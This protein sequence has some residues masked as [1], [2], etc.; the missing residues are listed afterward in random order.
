MG[1]H[2]KDGLCK[3]REEGKDFFFE[4]KNLLL[5]GAR[6]WGPPFRCGHEKFALLK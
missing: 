4:K 2:T 3:R 1:F 6:R 5:M